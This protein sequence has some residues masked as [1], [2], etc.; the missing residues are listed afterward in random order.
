MKLI[1]IITHEDNA[2][3]LEQTLLDQK[4]SFT[5]LESQGGFLKKRNLTF[6]LA[7]E[8][9][10]VEKLIALTKKTAKTK[11]ETVSAPVFSGTEVENILS[12]SST[13]NVTVGGATIF[14]LP[15]EK[16]IKV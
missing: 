4:H 16:I 10:K 12:S 3:D 14:V 5:K 9:E 8:D 1:L 7:T 2:P 6:L 13:V 11:Q 15:L